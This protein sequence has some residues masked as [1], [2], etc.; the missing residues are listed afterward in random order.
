MLFFEI[1]EDLTKIL[2]AES[3][4]GFFSQIVQKS[5]KEIKF[6]KKERN[7]IRKK[8]ARKKENLRRKKERRKSRKWRNKTSKR[9]KKL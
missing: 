8:K 4:T 3:D 7:K 5:K 2:P 6:K 9:K 1:G